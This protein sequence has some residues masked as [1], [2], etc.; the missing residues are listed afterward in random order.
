MFDDR[1]TPKGLMEEN[2]VKTKST[3]AYQS[4]RLIYAESLP[5]RAHARQSEKYLYLSG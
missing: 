2:S 5:L 3:K 1:G 4:W